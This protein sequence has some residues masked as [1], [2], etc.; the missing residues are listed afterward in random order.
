MVRKILLQIIE[1]LFLFCRYRER[2]KKRDHIS[3][4]YYKVI[5][6]YNSYKKIEPV[7]KLYQT[8]LG[9][10]KYWRLQ[11]G[12]ADLFLGTTPTTMYI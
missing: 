7:E 1:H 11:I 2:K 9:L 3:T 10:R 12:W 6:D 5:V 8:R 4:K